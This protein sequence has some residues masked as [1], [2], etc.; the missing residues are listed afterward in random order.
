MS[1]PARLGT[2]LGNPAELQARIEAAAAKAPRIQPAP[3]PDPPDRSLGPPPRVPA[4]Y[5]G[6]L[7]DL[8]PA[9]H[10]VQ[11]MEWLEQVRADPDHSR[12]LLLVGKTGVG[13]SVVSGRIAV[14]LGAPMHAQFWPVV[15][16]LAALRDEIKAPRDR[17]PVRDRIAR[18]RL[19]VL[20]DIGAENTTDWTVGQLTEVIS[21]T[22]DRCG[23]LIAT[24][25]LTPDGLADHLGERTLSRLNEMTDLVVCAGPDRRRS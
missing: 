10:V 15:D 21:E 22:Y 3:E 19:L 9:P 13:K 24:T 25:N 23:L 16:L 20:D 5:H 12:G 14:A 11:A 1:E 17:I 2:L 18:R 4:R 8:D 7:A 6:A